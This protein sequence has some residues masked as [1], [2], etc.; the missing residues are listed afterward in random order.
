MN[1]FQW[2]VT[3]IV[4][5]FFM[6]FTAFRVLKAGSDADDQADAQAEK[7]RNEHHPGKENHKCQ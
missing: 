4:A 1:T 2:I 5:V 3:T 7:Y 6:V